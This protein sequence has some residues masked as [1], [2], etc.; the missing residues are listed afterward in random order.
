M[1]H[2]PKSILAI[3]LSIAASIWWVS[4]Q[5]YSSRVDE[6]EYSRQECAQDLCQVSIDLAQFAINRGDLSTAV[7]N[8]QKAI[9][10][11]PDALLPYQ[12]LSQSY[13]EQGLLEQSLHTYYTARH[14][15]VNFSV[16]R[17]VH[18][19]RSLLQN[20]LPWQG[21]DLAEKTL[22]I[23]ADA[24]I[25]DCICFARFLPALLSRG[26]SVFCKVPDVLLS[27][28]KNSMPAVHFFT[29]SSEIELP[30]FDYYSALQSIPALLKATR[31]SG[32]A[33]R[34]YLVPDVAHV[35]AKK[36]L[37]VVKKLWVGLWWQGAKNVTM[38]PSLLDTLAQLPHVQFY[39]LQ[40]LSSPSPFIIDL[41]QHCR[42]LHDTAALIKNMDLVL[43]IESPVAHLAGAVGTPVWL[44]TKHTPVDWRWLVAKDG[45]QSAWYAGLRI[46]QQ[47]KPGD[48]LS[49]VADVQEALNEIVKTPVASL[50]PRTTAI[51]ASSASGAAS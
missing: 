29:H 30:S 42:T 17:S 12:R 7:R 48:W 43:A 40:P 51:A 26:A 25:D 21:E 11:K 35:A 5:N 22:Y 14:A 28:C 45:Y 50:L 6:Q 3:T 19:S 18:D 10:H 36:S 44:L 16:A 24:D 1:R 33:I 31:G 47:P 2:H 15:T 32:L 39:A 46:F 9:E 34:S 4:I 27:L 41:S 20:P 49:V 13:Q 38:P 23:E 8:F 37:F